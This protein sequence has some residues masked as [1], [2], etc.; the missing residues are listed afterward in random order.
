M[1]RGLIG[2]ASKITAT[3]M[4]NIYKCKACYWKLAKGSENLHLHVAMNIFLSSFHQRMENE[5]TGAS[6]K[7]YT[8]KNLGSGVQLANTAT[9]FM[10][11]TYYKVFNFCQF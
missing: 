1:S 8:S 10:Y 11:C 2:T 6:V 7:V 5:C 9:K 3:V 4:K